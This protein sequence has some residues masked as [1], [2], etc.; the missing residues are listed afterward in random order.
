LHLLQ[1]ALRSTDEAKIVLVIGTKPAIG[2]PF[3][4]RL[5]GGLLNE[6]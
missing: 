1:Y 3:R 6:N 2:E 4:L 5:G